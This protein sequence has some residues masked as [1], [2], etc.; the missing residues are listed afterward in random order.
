MFKSINLSF[1]L[2]LL[3]TLFGFQWTLSK[4]RVKNSSFFVQ[5]NNGKFNLGLNKMM[6]KL[7]EYYESVGETDKAVAELD[8][9]LKLIEIMSNPNFDLYTKFLKV[10]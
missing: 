2:Q 9:V 4:R 1:F 7:S 6:E 3:L 8:N 5:F 10:G